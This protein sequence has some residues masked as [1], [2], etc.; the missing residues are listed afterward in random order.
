MARNIICDQCGDAVE[1]HHDAYIIEGEGEMD[2]PHGTM[3]F[4]M[5]TSVVNTTGDIIE[6]DFCKKCIL[7][8]LMSLENTTTDS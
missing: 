4:R 3:V 1:K 2:F 5:I 7:K 6:K 8:K